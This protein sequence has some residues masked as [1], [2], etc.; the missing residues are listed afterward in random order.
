M[1]MGKINNTAS[2][3][4]AFAENTASNST[5]MVDVASELLNTAQGMYNEVM[6][7]YDSIND[8]VMRLQRLYDEVEAKAK[9][10]E[11]QYREAQSEADAAQAEINYLYS[12]PTVTTSTD[13]DGNTT[14]SEEYDYAAIA[15]AEERRD[16]AQEQANYFKDLWEKAEEVAREI[17]KTVDQFSMI[18]SA[19]QAV[20]ESIKNDIYRINKGIS[21]VGEEASNNLQCLKGVLDSVRAY[22]ACKPISVPRNGDMKEDF[23]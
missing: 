13:D 18:R 8:Q 3:I 17:Q 5:A 19:I 9:S 6:Q 23:S 16:R 7:D 15:A 1:S 21:S 20:A 12:H 14:T 10:Y 4:T 2:G 22:L 11:Y